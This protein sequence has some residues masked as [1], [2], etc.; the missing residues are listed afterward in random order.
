M[1][2]LDGGYVP[3]LIAALVGLLMTT[4]V[5][6]TAIVQRKAHAD[7]IAAR[8]LIAMLKKSQPARAPAP[9]SS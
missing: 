5:R 1:K 4:W 8:Q 3:L 7:S 9:R 2:V 6:G